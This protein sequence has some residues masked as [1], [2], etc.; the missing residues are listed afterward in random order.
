MA[1]EI[2]LNVAASKA[3][4]DTCGNRNFHDDSDDM[5]HPSAIY[6]L[7]IG[8][9]YRQPS[10]LCPNCLGVLRVLVGPSNQFRVAVEDAEPRPVPALVEL[11]REEGI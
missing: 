3:R 7:H 10:Y 11:F 8:A 5:R 2:R 9:G 4:C 6:E 1:G